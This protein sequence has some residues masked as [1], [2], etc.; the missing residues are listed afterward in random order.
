MKAFRSLWRRASCVDTCVLVSDV[1]AT[2]A[3][4][5]RTVLSHVCRSVISQ[6]FFFLFFSSRR[7]HTRYWRD[8][9]SDV[10]SSDL[11]KNYFRRARGAFHPQ[12]KR[13]QFSALR[14]SI[15]SPPREP[16]A[17]ATRRGG[18]LRQAHFEICAAARNLSRRRARRLAHIPHRAV[19]LAR[20]KTGFAQSD[21]CGVAGTAT[22]LPD[23]LH[24]ASSIA[25][26]QRIL[27]VAL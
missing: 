26:S 18:F 7:R 19:Q 14:R 21:P 15:L 5:R 1:R 8:W 20:R 24:R 16:D 23:S 11:W 3:H 2:D 10:C 22:G 12:E 4:Q 6:A 25:R 27:S 9:S 13:F 17:G